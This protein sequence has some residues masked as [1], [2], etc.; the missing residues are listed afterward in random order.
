MMLDRSWDEKKVREDLIL[1]W[2]PENGRKT[3]LEV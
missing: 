2:R 1:K 3:V